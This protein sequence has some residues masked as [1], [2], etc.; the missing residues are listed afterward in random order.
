[1]MHAAE[2]AARFLHHACR[3]LPLR[4]NGQGINGGGVV[5]AAP[6]E[7]FF[8]RVVENAVAYFGSRVLY[9][10]RPAFE[11]ENTFALS[12]AACER[13]ANQAA[14]SDAEKFESIAQDFGYRLGSQIYDF[15]LAGKV[16]PAGV[17]RLFL[18]HLD[19]PGLARKVCTAVIGRVRAASCAARD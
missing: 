12:R 4:W 16:K 15:Y 9:P 11:S 17:R 18:A 1:M 8:R 10:S 13:A 7:N 5:E 2:D 14:G 3:G 6:A 19:G